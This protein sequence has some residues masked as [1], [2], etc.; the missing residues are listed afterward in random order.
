MRIQYFEDT[1]T[2]YLVFKEA[3]V[4]ETKDLDENTSGV[5]RS[6]Q[7]GQYDDRACAGPGGVKC[8]GTLQSSEYHQS[9]GFLARARL[10]SGTIS[11]GLPVVTRS[12]GHA[13]ADLQVDGSLE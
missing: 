13:G 6:G 10:G 11:E 4:D 3:T 5:R 12:R 9:P 7:S 2:L 1:D 8:K